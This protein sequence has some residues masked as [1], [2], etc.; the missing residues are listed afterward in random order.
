MEGHWLL[1]FGLKA[2]ESR[3]VPSNVVYTSVCVNEAGRW[4]QMDGWMNA[5]INSI[6]VELSELTEESHCH[7]IH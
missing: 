4:M 6:S 5:L 7:D 2:S 1:R 3:T